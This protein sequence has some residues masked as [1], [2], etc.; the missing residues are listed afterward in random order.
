MTYDAAGVAQAIRDLLRAIGEDPQREG[1]R[2]TPERIARS[3]AEIFAGLQDDPRQHMRRTFDVGHQELVLVR[4]IALYSMCEHHLLPFHGYAHVGYIPGADG[5]VVGLSK[6]ARLVEGYAR[7]PQVQERLTGQI[8]DA[9]SE[10]LDAAGVIVVVCAEHLC[11]SMR[12]VRKP[13]AS[14]LTSAVRGVLND[15][16]ARAQAMQLIMPAGGPR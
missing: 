4:D 8:A 14:T 9:L 15:P 3:Y 6:L 5:R 7:R 16:A 13:G 10:E 1:L 2:E 11:M 12:G